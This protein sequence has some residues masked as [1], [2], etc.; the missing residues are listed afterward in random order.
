M[1][2][3]S[4]FSA[5]GSELEPFPFVSEL[6][7]EG[8]LVENPEILKL[9]NETPRIIEIEKE[10]KKGDGRG[11]IDLLAYYGDSTIVV[12]ELKKDEVNLEA[13]A[14]LESYFESKDHLKSIADSFQLESKETNKFPW[15]GVLVGNSISAELKDKLINNNA[16]PNK[17]PVAAIVL[18]RFRSG[19][20]IFATTDVIFPKKGKDRSEYEFKGAK[21][22]KGRLVLAM[23]KAYVEENYNKLNASELKALV[24]DIRFRKPLLMDY[25]TAYQSDT[26]PNPKGNCVPY[27]FTKPGEALELKDG[28]K[29]A[30]LNWWAIDDMPVI[31]KIAKALGYN[32][33]SL[34]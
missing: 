10:W 16:D 15:L 19:N 6:A 9:D 17:V 25:D 18:N 3:Y 14:Q 1:N 31:S 34:P 23:F 29:L 12:V 21:Y 33:P 8:Y 20:Q 24:K 22:K 32:L 11:R 5:S 7:M 27:Y 26:T 30:V 2:I 13:F 4:H 28:A